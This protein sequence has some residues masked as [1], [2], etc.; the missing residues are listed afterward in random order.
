MSEINSF[1]DYASRYNT[2]MDYSALFGGGAPYI[3]NSIGG[4]NVSDYALIKN[5]SY[6]KLMKAYYAK[7]DADKLSQFGDSSQT[8]TLMRSSADSLKKSAE[9]LGDA[10]LYEK[11]KFKKRDEETG[12]EI[13]VE[14]YDWDA[15]TKAVKTFVDDY[16]S[17]VEQAGNSETKDVLRNAAWMTGI[18]EKAGNLLSKV[19]ITVGKGDKLE[20]DEEALK[21]K[22][23]LG[24]SSIELDNIS[25]LKSLF[26]GYGSFADKIAQKA[27]AISSVA[28][29]TKGV[30]KIYNKN[31]AYS[32]TIS[33]L[34]ESTID[35]RVGGESK[36][37][38]TDKSYWES[39]LEEEKEKNKTEIKGKY[40]DKED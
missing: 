21:K 9:A 23:T 13:E 6:G 31:G 17:L 16:N 5:G 19:G 8:L 32:D 28:A 27:S 18:T 38:V 14:D 39:K 3:D 2:N 12:E 7:Q 20:F 11:K 10:S 4:I 29:R 40:T 25:T 35:K 15:I 1:S 24:K 34:F 36:D 33:K 22:T 37:K 30:D 26:T